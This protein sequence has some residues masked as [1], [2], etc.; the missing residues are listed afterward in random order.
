VN[1]LTPTSAVIMG[2]LALSKVGYDKY[3]RFVWPFL[4][5]V[6]VVVCAF[7]GIAAATA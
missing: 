7:L 6:F 5:A 4:L 3:L 1:L 2:G